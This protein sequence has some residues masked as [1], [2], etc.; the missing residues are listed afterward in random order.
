ML[1][2]IKGSRPRVPESLVY[3]LILLVAYR[4]AQEIVSI[5]GLRKA[6]WMSVPVGLSGEPQVTARLN[7]NPSASQK[8]TLEGGGGTT[9]LGI[10]PLSADAR[11]VVLPVVDGEATP[12]SD[13]H[14][15]STWRFIEDTGQVEI[16]G[17]G[18]LGVPTPLRS[19]DLVVARSS[20]PGDMELTWLDQT[21]VHDLAGLDHSD[22]TIG[23]A[24]PS[25]RRAWI[26][27]PAETIRSLV[28]SIDTGG[29]ALS[30]GPVTI[31][32]GAGQSWRAEE[33]IPTGAVSADCQ[34]GITEQLGRAEMVIRG[35]CEFD[36]PGLRPLN[37]SAPLVTLALWLLL[38]AAGVFVAHRLHDA[39]Q[40]PDVPGS[41]AGA[42]ISSRDGE[43]PLAP[44]PRWGVVH[45]MVLVGLVAIGFHTV[46]AIFTPIRVTP[47]S[48]S[49][50]NMAVAFYRTKSLAAIDLSRTP[51]YPLF[52]AVTIWLFGHQVQGI[53]LLQHLT[54]AL[55]APLTVRFLYPRT[56]VWFA[57][58]GGL[59]VAALPVAT[60]YASH[61][62]TE[63]LFLAF[64]YSAIIVFLDRPPSI[65]SAAL[66]GLLAASATM[67]RPN[68]SLV[69]VAL[70]S[71]ALVRWWIGPSR[72]SGARVLL[73]R[74]LILVLV[75]IAA[76]T[77]WALSFRERTGHWGLVNLLD[78]VTWGNALLG[79]RL[80]A[81]LS[82]NAP[83]RTLYTYLSST[84]YGGRDPW[85]ANAI[86][87]GMGVPFSAAYYREA[88]R[89]SVRGLPGE[90]SDAVVHSLLFNAFGV[91]VPEDGSLMS[92][93]EVFTYT[94]VARIGEYPSP[95][96]GLAQLDD[97]KAYLRMMGFRWEPPQSRA[98]STILALESSG[99]ARWG[100]LTALAIV[101]A[102]LHLLLRKESDIL[103]LVV[104]A[105]GTILAI[106]LLPMPIDRYVM[107]VEPSLYAIIVLGAYA[108][109]LVLQRAMRR[110]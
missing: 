22:V 56:N 3:L 14:I 104:F 35:A 83:Y 2:R 47:D 10:C 67:V 58:L 45:S 73:T 81:D 11:V 28:L 87:T 48:V 62:W 106:T 26:L 90:Y 80:P 49:Y 54:I 70:V 20:D 9:Y 15:P 42:P 84:A 91:H 110:M 52:I 66:A 46:A 108:L 107:I 101:G 53:V 77:P 27:L 64:C 72:G 61:V 99:H 41:A 19:L 12:S 18:L 13:L 55:L 92:Y 71:W 98:R 38:S 21:Q 40:P 88:A 100:W 65:P 17:P 63:A 94:Y 31:H 103:P 59:A 39:Y 86:A 74:T 75:F 34:S 32:E 8:A 7:G 60:V 76:C 68:G 97:G 51:G 29:D 36:L 96:P 1:S 50:Y 24:A 30:L 78:D 95:Y 37:G 109:A 102:A 25:T 82:I 23:L 44:R 6:V 33:L 4:A 93:P 69:V 5:V 43:S 16:A 57:T 89:E 79:G 85:A 105:F